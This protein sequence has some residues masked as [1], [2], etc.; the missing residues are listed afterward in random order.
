[1]QHSP[2]VERDLISSIINLVCQLP[3]ELPNDVRPRKLGNIREILKLV[4]GKAQCPLSPCLKTLAIAAKN[5]I[6]T[7]NKSFWWLSCLLDFFTLS[8]YFFSRF[9]RPSFL[10]K[11]HQISCLLPIEIFPFNERSFQ[12]ENLKGTLMQILKSHDIFFFT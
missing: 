4:G 1:M 11:I 5:Y 9:F 10:I 3:D 8:D 6:E 2:Q 7:D 12:N